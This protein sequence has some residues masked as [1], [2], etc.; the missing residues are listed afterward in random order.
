MH[1]TGSI[2][3]GLHRIARPANSSGTSVTEIRWFGTMSSVWSNHQVDKAVSSFP[4]SGT[5]VGSDTS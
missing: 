2:F 3:S 4:L 5:G 1:S